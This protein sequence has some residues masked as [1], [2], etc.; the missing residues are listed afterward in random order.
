MNQKQLKVSPAL[1]C[2]PN[3]FGPNCSVYCKN[4]DD[5]YAG[6]YE[7]DSETGK[8][9]CLEGWETDGFG[10]PFGV[11]MKECGKRKYREIY[12]CAIHCQAIYRLALFMIS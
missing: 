5:D 11:V 2:S 4:S 7:C 3:Y 6:H 10:V 8:K 12:R 1:T 9:V